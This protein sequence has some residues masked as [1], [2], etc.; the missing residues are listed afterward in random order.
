MP[1]NER[2]SFGDMTFEQMESRFGLREG[3]RRR[4]F[5]GV[6]SVAPS[7]ALAE[8]I[9]RGRRAVMPNERARAYRLISPV[10]AELEELRPGKIVALPEIPLDFKEIEGLRGV[11]DFIL[12]GSMT[13]RVVPL[14]A[15]VEAKK[16]DTETGLPTCITELYAAYLINQRRPRVIHGCVTTGYDWQFVA[17]DGAT[18]TATVD[19][20]T[21]L[22]TELPDVLGVLCH[23]IDAA[24]A[25]LGDVVRAET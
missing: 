16:D 11:P 9:R 19:L 12:S 18:K 5:E 1:G 25:E 13:R 24:L 6:P 14:V 7:P 2:L 21:Y 23:A 3:P 15:I 20:E 22:L 10:L 8:M 4:L 17:L